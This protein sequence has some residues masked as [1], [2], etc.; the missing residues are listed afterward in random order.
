MAVDEYH[1]YEVSDNLT[2]NL[3]FPNITF[4][5]LKPFVLTKYIIKIHFKY[6]KQNLLGAAKMSLFSN[7]VLMI[8]LNKTQQ[9][10]QRAGT[11]I[12]Y[13]EENKD[14]C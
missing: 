7:R 2:A 6:T 11:K 5:T 3:P 8:Q 1:R 9:I 14:Q 10:K 4:S 12:D 13:L